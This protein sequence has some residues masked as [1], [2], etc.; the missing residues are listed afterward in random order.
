MTSEERK[1]STV[2]TSGEHCAMC[3]AA[4]GLVGL[5]RIVYAS[6]S[7]QMQQWRK[8]LGGRGSTIRSIPIE[9]IIIDAQVEGPV[10]EFSE[11]ILELHRKKA[12]KSNS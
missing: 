7:A 11:K 8:E 2:Y 9:E 12:K 4:H 1:S 6:S 10:L 3:S 5:G